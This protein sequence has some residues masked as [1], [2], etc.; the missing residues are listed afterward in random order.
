MKILL[1]IHQS[2]CAAVIAGCLAISTNE[3]SAESESVECYECSTVD[4]SSDCGDPF[5][6][7]SIGLR[8]TKCDGACVKWVVHPTGGLNKIICKVL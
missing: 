7:T 5:N 2:F 3:C 6:A 4:G 8:S 1:P